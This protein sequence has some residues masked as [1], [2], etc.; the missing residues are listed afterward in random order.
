MPC[1]GVGTTL[2]L[3]RLIN[4]S[5]DVDASFYLVVL[6]VTATP[7]AN[8]IAV[9][10]E[11]GNQDKEALAACIFT[12]YLIAPVLLTASIT[13]FMKMVQQY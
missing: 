9:M 8:N 3:R 7:T 5:E 1:I 11:F 12:Q 10:A 6:I 13:V 4:V 2:L